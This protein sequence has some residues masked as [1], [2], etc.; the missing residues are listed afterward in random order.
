MT[1][2]ITPIRVGP[3][4]VRFLVDEVESQGAATVFEFSVPA[5]AM[6]PAAHSHDAFE[7]TVYGL[8]GVMTFTVDGVIRELSPGE[9]MV[10]RRGQ[11]HRF[12]NLGETDARVLSVATPGVFR[13]AY[14]EEVAA[15]L[16]AAAGGPPDLGALVETMQRHGLTPALP[17]R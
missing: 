16:D 15:V 10:I 2:T 1:A 6:V 4:E 5:G 14:F 7:E 11:I 8:D 3:I 9:A 12:D 17:P 13:P